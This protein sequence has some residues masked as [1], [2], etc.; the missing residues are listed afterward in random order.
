[1]KQNSYSYMTTRRLVGAMIGTLIGFS[2]FLLYYLFAVEFCV[3]IWGFALS[4][5]V[6]FIRFLATVM[7][8]GW[9][10]GFV[11]ISV[12]LI[13]GYNIHTIVVSDQGIELQR[14]KGSIIIT[15][16]ENLVE[17]NPDVSLILEGMKPDGERISKRISVTHVGKKHWDDF[18]SDLR[19]YRQQQ[20]QN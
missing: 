12:F 13:S 15:R 7:M 14:R 18:K 4:S 3:A 5:T 1:M 2:I 19:T 16:I 10:G 6:G 9:L 8:V 11:A 17:R 20:Q